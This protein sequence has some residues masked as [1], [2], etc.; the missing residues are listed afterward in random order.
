VSLKTRLA[1]LE[2]A[3]PPQSITLSQ[4]IEADDPDLTRQFLAQY[5]IEPS[6]EVVPDKIER[7]L[8]RRVAQI[9]ERQLLTNSLKLLSPNTAEG[10]THDRE[11]CS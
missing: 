11:T 7:E 5:G 10:T 9:Q 1:K 6:A 3:K 8:E 2:K 4:A